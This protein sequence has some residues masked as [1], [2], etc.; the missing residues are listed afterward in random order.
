MVEIKRFMISRF[1]NTSDFDDLCR[2]L[3]VENVFTGNWD[4]RITNLIRRLESDIELDELLPKL[5]AAFISCKPSLKVSINRIFKKIQPN[6]V[7]EKIKQNIDKL[8]RKTGMENYC[9]TLLEQ[10]Q[11]EIKDSINESDI[12]DVLLKAGAIPSI[13][14]IINALKCYS[15]NYVTTKDESDLIWINLHKIIGHLIKVLKNWSWIIDNSNLFKNLKFAN[16]IDLPVS[17]PIGV[18]VLR[19]I[20]MDDYADLY[21]DEKGY[22]GKRLIVYDPPK[23]KSQAI[24]I[25]K[26]IKIAI[27]HAIVKE[28]KLVEY[29]KEAETRIITR[30]QC[31]NAINER[32]FLV[33]KGKFQNKIEVLELLKGDSLPLSIITL[34]PDFSKN[35]FHYSEIEL[36]QYIDEFFSKKPE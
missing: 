35:I 36:E 14:S 16:P 3:N 9:Q 28:P 19:A 2:K 17:T 8:F 6:K 5:Y 18:E 10:I 4:S 22:K 32:Q 33:I 13:I 11:S 23:K 34:T 25:V 31:K 12:P 26:E 21:K 27:Y 24:D 1:S 30:L 20:A 29:N 7:I 15:N